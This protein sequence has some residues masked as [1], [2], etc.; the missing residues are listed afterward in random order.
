M[1]GHNYHISPST[2]SGVTAGY[3]ARIYTL[4]TEDIAL[5][6]ADTNINAH[7]F[8][9]TDYLNHFNEIDMLIEMLPS[10]PECME[11]I[12]LWQPKTYEEHFSESGFRDKDLA[13]LAYYRAP[14]LVK[15]RFD[16]T[17]RDLD[18]CIIDA[19][20]S[21]K[22]TFEMD[23]PEYLSVLIEKFTVEIRHYIDQASAIINGYD[24]T[25]CPVD[26]SS[27]TPPKAESIESTQAA[28]DELF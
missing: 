26:F 8:L 25:I 2:D 12:C 7:T 16:Q 19:I 27:R 10:M 15:K 21:L 20:E 28:V 22:E 11:D 4:S 17:I 6:L 14:D 9:A 24:E 13:I 1:P 3:D 18:R 5:Q 23:T